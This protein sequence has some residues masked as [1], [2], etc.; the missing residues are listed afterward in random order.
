MKV[1]RETF[2]P[3]GEE[4]SRDFLMTESSLKDE[5]KVGGSEVSHTAHDLNIS[6]RSE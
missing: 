3:E 6:E 2:P 1:A 4:L 5:R